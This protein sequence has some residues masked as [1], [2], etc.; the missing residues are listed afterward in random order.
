MSCSAETKQ[1][2]TEPLFPT[3]TQ[4][5]AAAGIVLTSSMPFLSQALSFEL[6]SW[7]GS[8]TGKSGCKSCGPGAKCPS[9]RPR[10]GV[11]SEQLDSKTGFT[12]R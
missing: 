11:R 10:S 6:C 3:A 1:R 5:P 9:T 2:H 12:I 8:S 7:Q 4:Q